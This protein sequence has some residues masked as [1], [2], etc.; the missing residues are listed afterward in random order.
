MLDHVSGSMVRRH[1]WD[2]Y[3]RQT[4]HDFASSFV[5]GRCDLLFP[6]ESYFS[7][8]CTQWVLPVTWLCACCSLHQRYPSLL[9]SF[10]SLLLVFKSQSLPQEDFPW[11]PRTESIIPLFV[12]LGIHGSRVHVESLHYVSRAPQWTFAEWMTD[13]RMCTISRRAIAAEV[14]EPADAKIQKCLSRE[15]WVY[16]D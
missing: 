10:S 16:C 7:V 14:L 5:Q 12:A 9:S 13:R 3:V 15:F 11:P 1:L 4:S 6:H 8:A 2:P